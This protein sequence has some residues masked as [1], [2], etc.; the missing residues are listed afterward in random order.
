MENSNTLEM[1][2]FSLSTLPELG[3]FREILDLYDNKRGKRLIPGWED[4]D[5]PEFIG[6]HSRIALSKRENDDLQFRIFGTTFVNLFARDLTGQFLI[7]SMPEDQKDATRLHFL[8][9]MDRPQIGHAVGLV[10]TEERRFLKFEVLDLPL[11]GSDG[12]VSHFLHVCQASR[13]AERSR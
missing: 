9:L 5:F 7:A 8:S 13:L 4:F 11:A 10:P 6:W 12:T 2:R 1:S 3:D